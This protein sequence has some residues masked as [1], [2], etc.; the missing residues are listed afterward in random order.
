V[1][2]YSPVTN[3]PAFE[4]AG[5]LVPVPSITLPVRG[6]FQ[7][8]LGLPAAIRRDLVRFDP[9]IVHVATPDIL[10]TRA[11]SF[12]KAQGVP[13]V[14]SQHTLF[15]TYLEH[16]RLGWLRP[17]A[18][19][20]LAR[21][22]RR[23]D[24]V[25]APTDQLAADMRQ[26]RGDDAVSVWSRG[27]D[28]ALFDPARRDLAWRR[29]LG[30]G[31]DEI[32]LLFF[33][34]LVREKGVASFIS[35]TKQLRRQGLPVRALVVGEGPARHD[36]EAMGD[37]I[38]LGHLE[39]ESL[40]R[41]VASA[42]IFYHPSMTET[43]G[44]VVLEAMAAGLPVVAADAPSSRALLDDGRAGRLCPPLGDAAACAALTA[45]ATSPAQRRELGALARQRSTLYSWDAA[46][47]AVERVYRAMQKG[48]HQRPS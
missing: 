7:L 20:H 10:G 2:V 40:A 30:V 21:F 11:Q 39:G 8:A 18:E 32:A 29:A 48:R 15:E 37:A 6:E 25:L 33:G 26:L 22:Y 47:A 43:F 31:D 36:F 46:S 5:T 3:T 14:A 42:D 4:P 23:S 35:V 1:R 16:Y 27:V 44:N 41:A 45:L 38:V 28:R 17:L 19:A 24:H 34:R 13:I 12:A 9:D